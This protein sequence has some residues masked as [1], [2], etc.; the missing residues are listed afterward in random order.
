MGGGDLTVI[1]IA[2]G[3]A[4]ILHVVTE[5]SVHRMGRPRRS[6]ENLHDALWQE[7]QMMNDL[8]NQREKHRYRAAYFKME[9]KKRIE[10]QSSN[11]P[12]TENG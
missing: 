9:I 11:K 1:T 5:E 6:L 3:T 12:D 10:Q 8:D 4:I 7:E 2:T